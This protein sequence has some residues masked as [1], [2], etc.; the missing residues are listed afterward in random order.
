MTWGYFIVLGCLIVQ[1]DC[2]NLFQEVWWPNWFFPI[3][4]E[5]EK[6]TALHLRLQTVSQTFFNLPQGVSPAKVCEIAAIM[7]SCVNTGLNE[8]CLVTLKATDACR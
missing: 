6:T 8:V 4:S 2:A 5:A 7:T 1:S 3:L